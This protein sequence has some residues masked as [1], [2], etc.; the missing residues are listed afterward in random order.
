MPCQQWFGEPGN[1]DFPS[2][3]RIA[4]AQCH[5]YTLSRC[6]LEE[7]DKVKFI[8]LSHF[9]RSK[10]PP[11]HPDFTWGILSTGKELR[12][13]DL[14]CLQCRDEEFKK[15][16]CENTLFRR[17]YLKRCGIFYAKSQSRSY[18][19]FSS[20]KIT[21]ASCQLSRQGDKAK[22]ASRQT[23]LGHETDR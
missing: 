15:A 14:L 16:N 23:P 18:E 10:F 11:P 6:S 9:R 3:A 4:L 7:G 5:Q 22:I 12:A 20:C 8:C 2:R 13:A 17:A 1:P 21:G 19:Y